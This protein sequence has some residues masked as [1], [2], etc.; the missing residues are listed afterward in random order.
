MLTACCKC[1]N[2]YCFQFVQVVKAFDSVDQELV[3]IKVIK[4]KKPFF[5]QAQIELQLLELM[6]KIDIN[7]KYYIGSYIVSVICNLIF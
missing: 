3:A 1:I 5:N 4:N 6:N 2:L 7:G